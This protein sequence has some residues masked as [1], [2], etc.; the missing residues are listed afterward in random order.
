MSARQSPVEQ[1]ARRYAASHLSVDRQYRRD[2]TALQLLDSAAN[3]LAREAARHM[4]AGDIP[5]ARRYARAHQL[6][7]ESHTRLS[8][9]RTR[10]LDAKNASLA[11]EHGITAG[12]VVRVTRP[13]QSAPVETVHTVNDVLGRMLY[14]TVDGRLVILWAADVERVGSE[15]AR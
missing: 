13:G 11:A 3:S 10:A 4:V 12:D 7:A 9:R 6:I 1:D 8:E 2:Q 14:V 15:V 5:M